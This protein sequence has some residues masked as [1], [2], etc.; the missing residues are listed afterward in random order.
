MANDKPDSD[1]ETFSV[2]LARLQEDVITRIDTP[3][4]ASSIHEVL[5]IANN[6]NASSVF[7]RKSDGSRVDL[8]KRDGAWAVQKGALGITEELLLEAKDDQLG[9]GDGV[10]T[11]ELLHMGISLSG[12]EYSCELWHEE[13]KHYE[14]MQAKGRKPSEPQEVEHKEAGDVSRACRLADEILGMGHDGAVLGGL[15]RDPGKL[16]R[17]IWEDLEI[18]LKYVHRLRDPEFKT[19]PLGHDLLRSYQELHRDEQ[20]ILDRYYKDFRYGNSA[21]LVHS[22]GEYLQ[23][24]RA[25]EKT[26]NRLRYHS[27]DED[28]YADAGSFLAKSVE[29]AKVMAILIYGTAEVIDT[30]RFG[31]NEKRLQSHLWSRRCHW[32]TDGVTRQEV[33]DHLTRSSEDRVLV[34]S[35]IGEDATQFYTKLHMAN[36]IPWD[37]WFPKQVFQADR[38]KNPTFNGTIGGVDRIVVVDARDTTSPAALAEKTKKDIRTRVFGPDSD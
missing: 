37:H 27:L 35:I 25:N 6:A 32:Q 12:Y 13:S 20:A 2:I 36:T 10:Y 34:I 3:K 4:T 5:N 16:A 26:F 8:V 38:D 24:I 22:V 9:R 7:V 17:N 28:L 18:L 23:T 29:S 19:R 15:S 14:P 21:A 11:D 30:A 33:G 1:T 31:P